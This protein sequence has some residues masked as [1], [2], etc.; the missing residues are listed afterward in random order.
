M[1]RTDPVEYHA[2]GKKDEVLPFETTWMNLE[3]IMLSEISQRK[4]IIYFSYVWN[5]TNKTNAQKPTQRDQRD[6]C[7]KGDVLGAVRRVKGSIV[8]NAAM[9]AW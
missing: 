2:A 1:W 7:Q 3:D 5:L 8:S 6:G 9:S 4:T